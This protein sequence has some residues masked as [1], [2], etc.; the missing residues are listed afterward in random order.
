MLRR[1][2]Q[3][4]ATMPFRPSRHGFPFAGA[5]GYPG[6]AAGLAAPVAPGFGLAGGM[7]WAALDR[8]L[9][10]RRLTRGIAQPEP[11][12]PLHLELLQRQ[13]NAVA[14]TGWD[15]LL[16][17]QAL[18]DR[19]RMG[20]RG[21]GERSRREWAAVRR[22]LDA[23]TPLLL[24]LIRV[25]GAFANP[26]ENQFVLAYR[27]TA[28]RA[29]GKVT[30]W[31]YDPGRPGD[32]DVRLVFGLRP[33]R[34]G[35][36]GLLGQQG[37]VRGF[38]TVPYDRDAAP[39]LSWE[40]GT[41]GPAGAGVP[42]SEPPVPLLLR[43]RP[44]HLFGRD[45][46]GNLIHLQRAAG[47]LR[48]D[49][50]SAVAGG[51]PATRIVG[52]PAPVAGHR[53][54]VARSE[55][56]ELVEFRHRSGRGW[57]ARSVTSVSGSSFSIDG[58]PVVHVGA[59]EA[60]SVFVRRGGDL[61]HFQR[62]R[63]GGWSAVDLTALLRL[64]G[65]GPVAGVAGTL[66][67]GGASQHVFVRVQSGEVIHLQ[68]STERAWAG[69][70][71][72]TSGDEPV[73]FMEDPSMILAPDGRTVHLFGRADGGRLIHL[74]WA[75][76]RSWRPGGLMA[77]S[78]GE[79]S[80]PPLDSRPCALANRDALHLFAR[81][82]AGGLFHGW[83]SGDGVWRGEDITRT[84][85]VITPEL[86]IEGAP[87]AIATP[88]GSIHVFA[89][90]GGGLVAYRHGS[91]WGWT[92][93]HVSRER[94][95]ESDPALT[96]DP[97]PVHAHDGARIVVTDERGAV[98]SV[99]IGHAVR[100]RV[101]EGM[102]Q[103]LAGDVRGTVELAWGAVGTLARGAPPRYAGAAAT[104]LVAAA[105]R[106]G[107]AAAAWLR[108][109]PARL[110]RA[111]SGLAGTG[112]QVR[113]A[114]A[115]VRSAAT[116]YRGRPRLARP[117]SA[118]TTP[119]NAVAPA[120][121]PLPVATAGE[122]MA[123]PVA[124]PGLE[125][126]LEQD[127]E[128]ALEPDVEP[129]QEP[130]AEPVLEPV[131]EQ[132]HSPAEESRGAAQQPPSF[133]LL[134]LDL[135]SFEPPP[136][137]LPGEATAAF[138]AVELPVADLVPVDDATVAVPASAPRDGGDAEADEA[139]T[140]E[141]VEFGSLG[142]PVEAVEAEPVEPVEPVEAEPVETPVSPA[143]AVPAAGELPAPSFAGADEGLPDYHTRRRRPRRGA[144][145]SDVNPALKGL[146][147]L[148]LDAPA[149]LQGSPLPDPIP[150]D[151]AS[152]EAVA[153]AAEEDPGV[154]AA[155][156][157]TDGLPPAADRLPPKEV[158]KQKQRRQL[159]EI[160][161]ILDLGEESRPVVLGLDGAELDRHVDR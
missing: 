67:V 63:W 53:W 48:S 60:V 79:D 81:T 120:P 128:P 108:L 19:G 132:V 8:Y 154:A 37:L 141:P 35:L 57:R 105:V 72:R 20:G 93:E 10:G 7:C 117:A 76:G 36:G 55:T 149:A 89:R 135:L 122:R 43:G 80:A 24:V 13:A 31:V 16:A 85:V 158:E 98:R 150:A 6:H 124:E 69:D 106:L 147:L 100:V 94:G 62:S 126:V 15:R 61:L 123:G 134:S 71:V 38:F 46:N 112:A 148:D 3:I 144:G 68:R 70:L 137:P 17:W 75:G 11:G 97:V 140:P 111:R 142:A 156:P 40:L 113:H 101:W 133:D 54:V 129:V 65:H 155:R 99:R 25:R 84:R 86:R 66:T 58:D 2:E 138:A 104:R 50:V 41:A 47:L 145:R 88:D 116:P 44:A 42:L 73:R 64:R 152:G 136:A 121:E 157:P 22:S 30:V 107:G 146:P 28:D 27:Y 78:A 26:T 77:E 95:G 9:S 4:M 56:G 45:R 102:W 29:T 130:V 92:V 1:R 118:A 109:A 96:G 131:A 153:R 161:R 18:P 83:S 119:A 59:R 52:I 127:Q 32:D 87:R 51:L 90:A 115:R 49:N 5:F 159:L 151:P 23:G 125:P 14:R 160:Q 139:M 12:A 114:A 21:L 74:R 39:R 33:L 34:S 82:E 110:D 91:G 103:R 143:A